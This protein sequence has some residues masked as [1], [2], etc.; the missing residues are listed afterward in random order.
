METAQTVIDSIYRIAIGIL[1]IEEEKEYSSFPLHSNLFRP[2]PGWTSDSHI[3]INYEDIYSLARQAHLYETG[4]IDNPAIH[5]FVSELR[6]KISHLQ[7]FGHDFGSACET[8][9]RHIAATVQEA[10]SRKASQTNHLD[11]FLSACQSG[12]V[13]CIGTLSHDTHVESFLKNNGVLLADGF[14]SNSDPTHEGRRWVENFGALPDS[15]PS[16]EIPFLKLHGSVDWAYRDK[17]LFSLPIDK[18]RATESKPE[19]LIGTFNKIMDYSRGPFL[20]IH[21]QF[22]KILQGCDSLVVCGYSFKDT[23]INSTIIEWFETTPRRRVLIID[24]RPER[25]MSDAR[26]EIGKLWNFR[27]GNRGPEILADILT[28]K[29]TNKFIRPDQAT[30]LMQATT[31]IKKRL[32]CVDSTEIMKF[33]RPI[34]EG[35]K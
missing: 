19:I 26:G 17:V 15:L 18:I 25:L 35:E 21:Y 1:N 30:P 22:R 11:P 33:I 12:Q 34:S 4:D 16:Q 7:F 10:L 2:L 29:A 20:A 9:Y 14:S 13:M 32:Q 3:P 6:G 8:A 31:V 27:Y 28:G 24:P 5:S 23:G